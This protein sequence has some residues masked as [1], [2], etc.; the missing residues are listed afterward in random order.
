MNRRNTT[1]WVWAVIIFCG[2]CTNTRYLTDSKSIERQH[3]MRAHR[4]GVNLGDAFL[5]VINLIIS[6]TLNSGFE[7]TQSDRAFKR[8]KIQNESPD[9]LF[10]NMVTD[11]VWKETGYCDIM[12]IALPPKARQKLLVPYPAAYNVYFRT[13]SSEE[14]KLEMRTDNKHRIIKLKPGMK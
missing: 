14:E 7:V 12:G 3:D 5:N 11:V 9:S 4:A 2:G 1:L 10:I 6:G 8:I 13:S